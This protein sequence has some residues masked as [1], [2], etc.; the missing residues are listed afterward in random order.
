MSKYKVCKIGTCSSLRGSSTLTYNIGLDA[1]RQI[2]IR[3]IDNFNPTARVR[4]GSFSDEWYSV[5]LLFSH[6]GDKK[7]RFASTIWKK[8]IFKGKDKDTAAFL[9]AVLWAEG[10][11]TPVEKKTVKK[12]CDEENKYIFFRRTDKDISTLLEELDCTE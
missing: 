3:I 9:M 11:V 6:I 4:A 2:Y 10:L 1:E 5:A 12:D 8:P 7:D